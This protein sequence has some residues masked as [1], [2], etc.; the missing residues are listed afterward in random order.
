MPVDRDTRLFFDAS[1]LIAAARSPT[2]GSAFLL[3]V[4][5]RGFLHGVVSQLVLLEAERNVFDNFGGEAVARY[6]RLV[7]TPPLTV[8]A[9][10]SPTI[11][12][13]YETIVGQKDAHVL[14]AAVIA[15]APFLITLDQRLEKRVN[16]GMPRIVALSPGGFIRTILIQHRDYSSMR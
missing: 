13:S 8:V 6:D 9:L 14:A 5:L 3:S 2:G 4:C 11:D 1:C 10:S 12:R 15:E 16:D 7:A